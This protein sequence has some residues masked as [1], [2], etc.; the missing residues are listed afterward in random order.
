MAG[1]ACR[2]CPGSSDINLF[3]YFQCVIDLDAEVPDRAFYLGM[4]KQE[5]DS[6]EVAGSPID[7][8][9]FVRRSEFVPNSR[10]PVLFILAGCHTA[11]G[12]AAA[13]E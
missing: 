7:Q 5:L 2:L 9:S 11:A 1:R 3:R 12:S 4:P 8:G 6:P 13:V 10:G